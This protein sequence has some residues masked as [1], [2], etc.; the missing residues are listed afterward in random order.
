MERGIG[1]FFGMFVAVIVGQLFYWLFVG[2]LVGAAGDTTVGLI[3]ISG[4]G[5]FGV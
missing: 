2:W 5:T 4:A 3:E 1:A